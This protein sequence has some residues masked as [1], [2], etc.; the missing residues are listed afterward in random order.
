MN[1]WLRGP[2]RERLLD[3][4]DRNYL[5]RQ[6]IFDPDATISFIRTYLQEGDR[7]KWS[8][9]NYSKIVWPYFVFQQW[10]DTYKTQILA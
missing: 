9:R 6:G 3:W 8:G 1:N 5:V 2:L 4:T 7:G 10:Y